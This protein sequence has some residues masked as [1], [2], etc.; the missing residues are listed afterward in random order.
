MRKVLGASVSDIVG[1]L[2]KEFLYLM[3]LANLIA[4]TIAYYAMQRWL[5]DFAY[6]LDLDWM[7]FVLGGLV[8]AVIALLTISYQFIKSAWANPIDALRGE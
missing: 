7:I 3:I 2:S 6:R 4:W 5:Q 8:S 1:C